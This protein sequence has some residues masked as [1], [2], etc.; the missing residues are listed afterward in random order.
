M[1]GRFRANRS[2]VDNLSDRDV[3]KRDAARLEQGDIGGVLS[4]GFEAGNDVW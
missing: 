3:F 2:L 4:S 1:R